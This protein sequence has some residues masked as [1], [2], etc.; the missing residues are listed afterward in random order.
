M[1]EFAQEICYTLGKIPQ[2]LMQAGEKAYDIA[3]DLVLSAGSPLRQLYQG[4][5]G[6]LCVPDSHQPPDLR[7][8]RG[9]ARHPAGA[10][11]SP[12]QADAGRGVFL[13]ADQPLIKRTSLQLLCLLFV[14]HN[15]KIC[16]LSFN[17][18]AGSPCIFPSH[19]F[20]ELLN[21]PEHK[22]GGFL[23]KKYPAQ[24]IAVPAHDKY[25]LYDIDTP[26]DIIRLSAISH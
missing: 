21:L 11:H 13:P 14:Y 20:N 10:R 12:C 16:R 6:L 15:D 9:A 8:G 26:D 2:F 17:G 23:I 3:A 22:G 1:V 18:N 25:E 7:V 5:A 19:Y 4:G 24:V